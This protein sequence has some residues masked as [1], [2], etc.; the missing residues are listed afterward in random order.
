MSDLLPENP[1]TPAN[2]YAVDS[3]MEMTAA[4]WNY[5]L[6]SIHERLAAREELEA[7]F[8]ALIAEGTSA[9]LT[10]VQE[11][12]APQLAALQDSIAA[13]QSAI[14]EMMSG[15]APNAARLGNQLP[16]YY[17]APANF[18][19]SATVKALLGAADAIGVHDAIGT[20]VLLASLVSLTGTQQIVGHKRFTSNGPI[21]TP[22]GAATMLEAYS[23]SGANAA[24]IAFHRAGAHAVYFGLDTDN[25]LKFGGWSRGANAYKIW[26]EANFNP[27]SYMPLG[28]GALSPGAII[29]YHAEVGEKVRLYGGSYGVGVQSGELTLWGSISAALRFRQ[30]GLTGTILG[31]LTTS[32]FKLPSA[33]PTDNLHATSKQFVEQYVNPRAA[34]AWVN[35]NGTGTVA[36]RAAHNV[37][38]ITDLGA[39][40]YQMN[41]ASPMP[42]ANYCALAQSVTQGTGVQ[43]QYQ[44]TMNDYQTTSVTVRTAQSGTNSHSVVDNEIVCVAIFGG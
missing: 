27:S 32:G 11:N 15:T 12:V 6:G 9:A 26:H 34:K 5:I 22:S 16:G 7:D 29:Q 35:F 36:I 42:N 1:P 30:G 3:T 28:G 23:T 33:A 2:G 4:L 14:E 39:G 17:L 10:M 43:L 13:S 41:F 18:S 44:A 19:V 20:G 8:E 37:S 40:T 21:A 38:S 24:M 25:E 31:E